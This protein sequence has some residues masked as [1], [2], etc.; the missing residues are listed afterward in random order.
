MLWQDLTST[1]KRVLPPPPSSLA[2]R[3]PPMATT[4]CVPMKTVHLPGQCFMLT[5]VPLALP[6]STAVL[7]LVSLTPV[8]MPSST[9]TAGPRPPSTALSPQPLALLPQLAL[10]QPA[11]CPTKTMRSSVPTPSLGQQGT[12]P[13]DWATPRPRPLA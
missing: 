6:A 1:H 2:P 11:S 10:T 13:T 5:T 12:P 3:T 4:T 8:A 7:L 9:P